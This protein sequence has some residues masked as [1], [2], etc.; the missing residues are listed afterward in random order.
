MKP[1]LAVATM[2]IL[3]LS[4]AAVPM[5]PVPTRIARPSTESVRDAIL[6]ALPLGSNQ[7]KGERWL[8]NERISPVLHY[9]S[10]D[11]TTKGLFVTR[12]RG[13]DPLAIP[14]TPLNIMLE[15]QNDRLIGVHVM[16][17]K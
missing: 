6:A 4:V 5:D 14:Y 3:A 12:R 11:G 13:T 1:I 9:Q 10:E 17:V 2:P 7:A 15:F 16:E 8:Y